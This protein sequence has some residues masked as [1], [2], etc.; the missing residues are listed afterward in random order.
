MVLELLSLPDLEG[1]ASGT[2][3]RGRACVAGAL[4]P[5]F[6]IAAALTNLRAG[7]EP[8]WHSFFVFVDDA[9]GAVVGSGGFKSAPIAGEV[10]IG[11]G[12]APARQRRGLATA[13][14]K[15]LIRIARAAPDV[16]AVVAKTAV[17]NA[18]SRRVVE[19]VGFRH[20]GNGRS[21]EDGELD[22]WRLEFQGPSRTAITIPTCV[23]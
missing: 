5:E 19:K 18:A 6:V 14:V 23:S 15:E 8:L 2:V 16:S 11:Y 21:E 3:V 22:I 10:E 12:V 20:S 13:A 7:K 17:V 4:P 1:L 9:D